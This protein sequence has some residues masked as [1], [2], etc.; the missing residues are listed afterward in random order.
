MRLRFVRRLLSHNKKLYNDII[1]MDDDINAAIERAFAKPVRVPVAL[2]IQ[3]PATFGDEQKAVEERRYAEYRNYLLTTFPRRVGG[4][5]P[6]T[7]ANIAIH[8]ADLHEAGLTAAGHDALSQARAHL[9]TNKYAERFLNEFT[10]QIFSGMEASVHD[11]KRQAD[12]F[13]SDYA[14][15][16]YIRYLKLEAERYRADMVEI[17]NRDLNDPF[18]H[19]QL[20]A[21]ALNYFRVVLPGR[22]D[23]NFDVYKYKGGKRGKRTKRRKIGKRRFTKRT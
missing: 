11:V 21:L 13:D 18:A 5:V 2:P 22:A 23:R 7:L 9:S 19:V 15:N 17:A 16:L 10:P 1:R 12:K 4:V 20:R 8:S 14:I 3:Y 6:V